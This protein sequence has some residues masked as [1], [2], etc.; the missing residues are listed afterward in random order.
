M[1]EALLARQLARQRPPQL[2]S[3]TQKQAGKS[4]SR[5]DTPVAGKVDTD[6]GAFDEATLAN[7]TSATSI[8]VDTA[9]A[10]KIAEARAAMDQKANIRAH[11]ENHQQSRLPQEYL[12]EARKATRVAQR[13]FN[14][15]SIKDFKNT[16]S[17]SSRLRVPLQERKAQQL[18]KTRK[19]NA[20]AS[21]RRER[22]SKKGGKK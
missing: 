14:K 20:K 19:S 2:S 9:V 12:K 11:V 22:A 13:V 7:P 15:G 1:S 6:T 21:Q 18:K 4:G 3:S 8:I 17:K 16:G 10:R 5:K